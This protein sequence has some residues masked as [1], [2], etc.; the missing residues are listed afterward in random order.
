MSFYNIKKIWMP[1]VYQGNNRKNKYFEGWYFKVVD[2]NEENIYAFIPGI[3]YG[4]SGDTS[5]CFIQVIDGINNTTHYFKYPIKEFRY[6]KNKF[7]IWVGDNYFSLEEMRLSI[8]S[9]EKKFKGNIKFNN[10][11]PW[12]VKAFSPGAMGWYTFVPLMECNHGILSLNHYLDGNIEINNK[13]VGFSKGKGY[14][15]KDWGSSFP[16]AWIWMQSNHFDDKTVSITASIAKIPWFKGEFTGFI[17]GLLYKGK[18]FRFTTYTGSKLRKLD[19]KDSSVFILV[20]DKNYILEII[21]FK[22]EGGELYSPQMGIMGN[23]INE[24]LTSKVKIRLYQKQLQ[25]RSLVYEGE[26]R[27]AGMEIT[28]INELFK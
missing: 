17:I 18:V 27:N 2:N 4:N 3:S 15:E 10:I 9:D 16:R 7:E 1:E 6:G 5:H 21:G 20:E 23:K 25:G 24:S 28:K 13:N 26:G 19:Y 22:E 14:I 11:T 8:I 12:P